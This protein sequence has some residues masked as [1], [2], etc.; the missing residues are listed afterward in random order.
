MRDGES[1]PQIAA[2]DQ[3]DVRTVSKQISLDR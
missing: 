1:P 3:F 2:A